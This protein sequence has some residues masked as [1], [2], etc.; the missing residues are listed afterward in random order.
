MQMEDHRTKK[1]RE[2]IDTRS[3]LVFDEIA[4]S[5]FMYLYTRI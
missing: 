2:I 1:C 5:L 3:F 4:R